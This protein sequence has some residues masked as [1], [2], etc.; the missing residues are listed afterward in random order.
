MK[1]TAFTLIT[2]IA[3]TGCGKYTEKQVTYR[4]SNAISDVSLSYLDNNGILQNVNF[5]PT[6]KQDIWSEQVMMDEG[7]IVYLSG[8]YMDIENSVRLDILIDGK[9]YKQNSS[10]GDTINYVIVSGTIPYKN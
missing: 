2:F 10:S 4:A 8:I 6:G 9:L 1:R 3:L 7:D 5:K